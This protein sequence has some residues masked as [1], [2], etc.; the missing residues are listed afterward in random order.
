MPVTN[1][2]R[3]DA[4]P[5]G[6]GTATWRASA[7]GHGEASRKLF[8]QIVKTLRKAH[9]WSQ[10]D[11]ARR[12]SDLGYP[13]HQTTIAKLE[14]GARPT[15]IE[16]M[17]A[18]AM[19]LDVSPEDLVRPPATQETQRELQRALL[20]LQEIN[21][22][23]KEVNVQISDLQT[24]RKSLA[25]TRG[26]RLHDYQVA[27]KAA[28]LSTRAARELAGSGDEDGIGPETA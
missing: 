14:S 15:P 22:R 26:D 13:M 8:G 7:Q 1:E 4:V 2:R 28:G 9:L 19:L 20:A 17:M 6:S 3:D 10:D 24:L 21:A 27:L 12:M 18:L 5:S 25:R 16:E 11:L 23:I